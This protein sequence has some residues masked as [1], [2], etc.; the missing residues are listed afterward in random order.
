MR[1]REWER[2]RAGENERVRARRVA[3]M[4][5]EGRVRELLLLL[6]ANGMEGGWR[7]GRKLLFL[8]CVVAR[9]DGARHKFGQLF[10]ETG[11]DGSQ[12]GSVQML[13][14]VAGKKID[15]SAQRREAA[16]PCGARDQEHSSNN[17]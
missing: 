14:L 2:E 1:E 8:S 15:R 10:V 4:E 16:P 12:G 3:M 13:F 7:S 17:K 5:A 9:L 6:V 11:V